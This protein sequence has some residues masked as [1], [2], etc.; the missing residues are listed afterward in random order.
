METTTK[1]TKAAANNRFHTGQ[2]ITAKGSRE[3]GERLE[4]Q[5]NGTSVLTIDGRFVAIVPNKG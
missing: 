1:L 3:K 4:D 2:K 5:G